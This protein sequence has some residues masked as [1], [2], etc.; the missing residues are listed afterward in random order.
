LVYYNSLANIDETAGTL[1]FWLK[2]RWSGNDGQD[3]YALRFG[4]GGGM[5]FGK[6]GG[7]YWR[8]IL[9]RYSPGGVPEQGTGLGV[10]DWQANEW[11]HVAFTWN[12]DS[13]KVYV[14][15][16]LK[17]QSIVSIDLP[18]VE[19]T[20]FQIGADGEGG[21][22]DG[23]V[24]ELRIS[25][26]ERSDAEIAASYINGIAILDLAIQ[27]N[28]IQ[29]LKTWWKTPEL[30]ALTGNGSVAIPASSAQWTS[31]NA[32][33][34]S[35][36]DQGRITAVAAG[37]TT[38]TASINNI[39]TQ[40]IVAVSA[41]VLEPTVETIDPFLAAP[42]EKY[43]YEM[44]VVV[45]RYLPTTDGVNVDEATTGL[46]S[47]LADLKAQIDTFEKRV[48]FILEEGSRFRG[49]KN[50]AARPSLG[51]RIAH[52]VTVYEPVPPGFPVPWNEGWYR[53][54]YNQILTRF[55]AQTFVNDLGVKEFWIWAYHHGGIE[56]AES[57]MSSPVTGDISN[58]ERYPD[59]LPIYDH[60]FF[61]YN[62]NFTRTQSEAVHN[63]GH[64]LE[65]ILGHVNGG[66]DSDKE[67]F[68]KKFVGQN[69]SGEFVTGRCGWTHMPPN[70]TDDYD[71]LNSN[72]AESDIEDWTPDGSGETTM[73][74]VDTWG[75]LE[76]AWPDGMMDFEQRKEAQF[77]IYW[78]Q[79]MP[80]YR[81]LI[82][83]GN[84][85]MTN[86]WLFTANWDQANSVS[87]G[88]YREEC[89][90]DFDFDGDIDG[91]DLA[92]LTAVLP[93][94]NISNLLAGFGKVDCRQP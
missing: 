8:S 6:D 56:P 81:N 2:P 88:L 23:V 76:F 16:D 90:A 68:W 24:D 34:A 38:V 12:S 51:Y 40:A 47:T 35:V 61:V 89:P 5:L 27:P 94:T 7:N 43:L 50:A 44:P 77:Y 33:I 58:S 30:I 87:V 70:T 78:M 26:I 93:M 52:I 20:L 72:L 64:Q 32:A 17:A 57:N 39:E 83:Y 55:D 22:L 75:G 31:S 49:Y 74:N 71:Y 18:M 79:S 69:E 86:W 1:E 85:Y 46:N 37:S 42:A 4:N 15:G 3:H 36:N 67:L 91:V 82:P 54:D 41:P 14:D 59:D 25:D 29:L 66:Y 21:Y 19:D 10:D 73:V 65:S 92:A 63:H 13:L 84:S 62:Y 80:G 60:T 53:P 11:H 9:N 48:K 28:P 45:I